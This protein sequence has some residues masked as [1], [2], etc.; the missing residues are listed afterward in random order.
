M[1]KSLDVLHRLA[2]AY[3][4]Q[5]GYHDDRGNWKVP[6]P[7]A[8]VAVLRALGAPVQRIQDAP[9]ALRER[10]LAQWRRPIGPVLVAW[11]GR[12]GEASL[13][14][15]ARE[16]S[17]SLSCRLELE[18]GEVRSWTCG[19]G[20]LLVAETKVV[21]GVAYQVRRLSLPGPLANGYHRLVL[22]FHGHTAESLVLSAPER[23][24]SPSQP[25]SWGG[26][27]PMYAIRSARDWGAGDFTD[28]ENLI[29]WVQRRG[30]SLVGTLPF[31]AAFLDQPFE[32]SPYAPASRLFWNEFFIDVEKVP[33]LARC[34]TARTFLATADF[35]QERAA[36]RAEK[37]VDYRR[38]MAL[39]RRVLADLSRTFFA[40]PS[41][42]LPAFQKFVADHPRVEDYARFRAVGETLRA[43]F[44]SWPDRQK[45]GTIQEGDYDE[46]AR[47]YHLYV[48]W[49]ADE[50]V[51]SLAARA[52][53][54]GPGMY[55]DM[56][57][58]VSSD[59]YD[60]WRDRD[61]FAA[62]VSAGAPPDVFFTKGQDWGFPP[63]HPENIRTQ[64]Y[65]HLRE[66][67]H[68]QLQFA[69]MLRIDHMM[70]LHRFY[71]VPHGLG[72][73]QGVYVTYPAE[74]LYAIYCL[75]AVRHKTV[76]VG[77]DLGTVPEAVRPA[78]A[79]HN[80][81]RL[82]VAQ[83]EIRPDWDW[84]LTQIPG[85]SVVSLNTH[86]LPTFRGFWEGLDVQDRKAM[87]LFDETSA[88][89]ELEQRQR[90]RDALVRAMQ[91]AGLLGDKV[92]PA[93]VQRAWLEFLGRGDG[94]VVMANLEDLWLAPYPQNVP[95]T[96]HERPNWKR[97]AEYPLEAF[98]RLAPMIETLAALDRGVRSRK[99]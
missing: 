42:R 1:T 99:G 91:R 77:E 74:E 55:L 64:G 5:L 62:N 76:L 16:A 35:Q 52:R 87:G 83:F 40:D 79:R 75:E 48:Q 97:K 9:A 61:A 19:V 27:L 18:S 51:C 94:Q 39:K 82:Y 12:P 7:E 8:I 26:F 86:D 10:T 72:A 4:V 59:S 33:E 22:Q 81:Y 68:T 70:G 32:P 44:A 84:P 13:R 49:I 6:A 93:A 89:Q 90:L 23:A 60:V 98:D 47:R 96:W 45:N 88:R 50:Q 67:L 34:E 43:S 73:K 30:G 3:G 71:W 14:M 63:L 56:P 53:A 31:L 78:M 20:E 2:E 37:M 69:G 29:A 25:H 92:N 28:L 57:L 21:E 58:G 85:G 17:G 54:N 41:G 95:G 46:D 80:V 11:E 38:L 15:A 65:R 66:C 24:P 36:L